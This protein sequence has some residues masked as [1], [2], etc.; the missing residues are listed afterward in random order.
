MKCKHLGSIFAL[1]LFMPV[2]GVPA[3]AAVD[4]SHDPGRQSSS[5][6]TIAVHEKILDVVSHN[7]ETRSL[8]LECRGYNVPAKSRRDSATRSLNR[9]E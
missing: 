2:L 9:C 4:A 7:E 8:P 1:A 3:M 5:Q 6:A